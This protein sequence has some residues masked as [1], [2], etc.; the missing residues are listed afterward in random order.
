MNNPAA[1]QRGIKY[2]ITNATLRRK[3]AGNKP[4]DPGKPKSVA[5]RDPGIVPYQLF[6]KQYFY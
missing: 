3:A 6:I 1:E 4:Q 2:T 5:G